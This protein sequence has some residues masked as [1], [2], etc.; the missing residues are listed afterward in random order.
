MAEEYDHE[1]PVKRKRGAKSGEGT[2]R[3][4]ERKAPVRRGKKAASPDP[5]PVTLDSDN[6]GGESPTAEPQTSKKRGPTGVKGRKR[7][8][9]EQVPAAASIKPTRQPSEVIPQAS[10]PSALGYEDNG[11]LEDQEPRSKRPRKNT[12]RNKQP[13]S[14]TAE[15]SPRIKKVIA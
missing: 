6:S 4:A 11:E 3:G 1:V 9:Q 14:E 12:S 5:E 13:S 10:Y 2:A 15:K 7:K 8:P